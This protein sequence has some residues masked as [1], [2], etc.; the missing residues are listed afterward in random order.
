MSDTDLPFRLGGRIAVTIFIAVLFAFVGESQLTQYVQTTLGYHHPFFLFYVLH[1]SFIISLPLHL[2]CLMLTTKHKPRVLLKGLIIALALQLSSTKLG[3]SEPMRFSR[4]PLKRFILLAVGITMAYNIPAL[5]WFAAISLASVTD[6]TAIWNANAF[7]A[8]VFAVKIM[9]LEWSLIRLGA[10]CLAIVGVLTVVYGGST[11]SNRNPDHQALPEISS[12]NLQ[13][14]TPLVGDLL[15]L[16]ASICYGLYQVL[17]KKYVALPSDPELVSE[18][19][20]YAHVSS[21]EDLDEENASPAMDDSALY[22]PPFGLYPN[23]L[24]STIGLCTFLLLW[25]PIP[26]LHYYAIEPFALPDNWTTTFF[27]AGI[28]L[29]GIIFNAGFMILLGLWGPIIISV[30]NLLTCVSPSFKFFLDLIS[31][32]PPSIVLSLF[33]DLMFGS[34]ALSFWGLLGAGT[35]IGA[36]SILVYDMSK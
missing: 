20:A 13:S 7:F 5:L 8:Y 31:P 27:I 32:I 17:Y 4:F 9:K 10:V 24:T 22:P 34:I 14:S 12:T 35:I 26:I 19:G 1:S 18:P 21:S 25:I 30:G 36:F 29:T 28:C 2:L 33:S 3:R 23:L 15:T 16:V 6:V 11:V